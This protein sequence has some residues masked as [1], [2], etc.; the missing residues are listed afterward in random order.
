MVLITVPACGSYIHYTFLSRA[1]T[2]MNVMGLKAVTSLTIEATAVQNNI[3]NMAQIIRIKR[4]SKHKTERPLVNVTNKNVLEII[5]FNSWTTMIGHTDCLF[6]HW[7]RLL[8]QLCLDNMCLLFKL[9]QANTHVR[10]SLKKGVDGKFHNKFSLDD[11]HTVNVYVYIICTDSLIWV[12]PVPLRCPG[13]NFP[14]GLQVLYI[15]WN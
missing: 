2:A 15:I 7:K 8:L 11:S 6:S 10:Q 4:M 14:V 13:C 1:T 12:H 5:H 9:R 3:D